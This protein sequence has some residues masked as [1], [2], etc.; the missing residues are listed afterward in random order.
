MLTGLTAI[1]QEAL[2]YSIA[3]EK[4][5]EARAAAMQNQPYNVQLGPVKLVASATLGLTYNDNVTLV[6]QEASDD[7]IIQP[8][9]SITANWPVTL[10]NAL[11]ISLGVGYLKYLENSQYDRLLI[12]PDSVISFDLFI[13][14]LRL[15][16][17]D[18]FS[19]SEDPLQVGA[20]SGV[21]QFGGLENRIGLRG[22]L[23]L[24]ELILTAGYDHLNF[25]SSTSTYSYLDRGS[26]LFFLRGAFLFQPTFALGVEGTSSLTDYSEPIQSDNV[27]F[28]GGIFADWRLS[29]RFQLQPRVGY[30]AYQFDTVSLFG[31]TEDVGTYYFN[32][33][34]NH[35]INEYISHSLNA[36]RDVQ[37]GI[38]SDTIESYFVRYGASFR[39]IRGV[40]TGAN[41]FYERG[42]YGS[43]IQGETYN[44]YGLGASLSYQLMQK[45][46][47][48]LSYQFYIKD[49][50]IEGRD[51][52]QNTVTLSFSYRF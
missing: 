10:K 16:F 46:S 23:D 45:L 51:Y 7:F 50:D 4:A 36:G 47:T 40:G 2:R 44:R 37:L 52:S 49:S 39:L 34:I 35:I 3:G 19:Y 13:K 27:G 15:N 8:Q 12:T 42:S 20:L 14:N 26:E 48:G 22:D 43:S 11:N 1:S 9:L 17:H 32:L 31:P 21:A 30:V 38:T 28:S 6:D 33:A 25:I 18:Y 29:P 24:N 5:A 41:L